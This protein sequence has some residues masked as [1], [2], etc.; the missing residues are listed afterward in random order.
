M[1]TPL[2]PFILSLVA[3]LESRS[4][5]SPLF[6]LLPE[7]LK[8][9]LFEQSWNACYYG[10]TYTYGD[11]CAP[12]GFQTS[13][14]NPAWVTSSNFAEWISNSGSGGGKSRVKCVAKLQVDP[15]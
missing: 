5:L 11:N 9:S 3:A 14:L 15:E 12:L 1:R 13:T 4:C 7:K 6:V 2:D 8:L 10:L